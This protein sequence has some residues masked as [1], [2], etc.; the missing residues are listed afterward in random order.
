M[1][2]ITRFQTAALALV[3]FA[4]GCSASTRVA[5]PATQGRSPAPPSASALPAPQGAL[6]ELDQLFLDEYQIA[7]E[8]AKR[9]PHP[10]VVVSG[11]N[12]TLHIDG[13]PQTVRVI[14]EIYHALKSVSHFAFATYLRLNPQAGQKLPAEFRSVLQRFL[15]REPPARQHLATFGLSAD[16]MRRQHVVLDA[17]TALVR[18]TRDQGSVT[19]ARLDQF[20]QQVG[21]LLLQNTHDAGCAQVQA[22]HRQMQKWRADLPAQDWSKLVVV[23]RSA[24]QARYRNAATTYFAW[25][26]DERAPDWSYPGESMR[27]IFAEVLFGDRQPLDLLATVVLDADASKA[28]FGDE[29]RLSEDVLSDGAADCV[30]K[31]P[32]SER[33]S[34]RG[35]Y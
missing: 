35:R 12:L 3:V 4:T 29:W 28:F 17:T 19:K 27:V 7:G 24:H 11:S 13:N 34:R 10:V 18:E 16:Q 26:L 25:L 5:P 2:P 22:T 14:P 33:W 32:A 15:D 8:A 21:P 30:G 20:A 1:K 9:P 23:N 6:G 31:L